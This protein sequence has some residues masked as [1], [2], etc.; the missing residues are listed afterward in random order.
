MSTGEDFSGKRERIVNLYHELIERHGTHPYPD[1]G[2]Y[3]AKDQSPW[4][5][6]RELSLSPY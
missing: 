1:S 2:H 6:K 4:K 5:K 3:G